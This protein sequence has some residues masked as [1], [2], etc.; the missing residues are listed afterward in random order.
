ASVLVEG[1][2][3]LGVNIRRLE[4]T[5]LSKPLAHPNVLTK[6]RVGRWTYR[7][8]AQLPLPVMPAER[9]ALPE[10]SP[11][12]I[13]WP[14]RSKAEHY[15]MMRAEMVLRGHLSREQYE[16]LNAWASWYMGEQ[17]PDPLARIERNLSAAE[18][19]NAPTSGRDEAAKAPTSGRGEG[20]DG[21]DSALE[22]DGGTTFRADRT[23]SDGQGFAGREAEAPAELPAPL[24]EPAASLA[25]TKPGPGEVR[26]DRSEERRG[27]KE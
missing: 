14:Y 16:S 12:R 23:L 7:E 24:E 19:T 25:G 5:E 17:Y 13:Y 22:S 21:H 2:V 3:V 1:I 26:E 15:A 27:G 8:P 9:A 10:E 6:D 4:H 18:A 11:E 20:R